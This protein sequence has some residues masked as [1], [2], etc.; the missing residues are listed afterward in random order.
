MEQEDRKVGR[1]EDGTEQVI[2]ALIEVRRTFRSSD[3]P[4]LEQP[5]FR[6]NGAGRAAFASRLL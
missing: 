3:L 5:P 6:W 4:V 1:F 2:G